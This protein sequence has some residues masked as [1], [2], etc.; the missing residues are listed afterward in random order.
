LDV[1]S[2]VLVEAFRSTFASL[3]SPKSSPR[4]RRQT[5]HIALHPIFPIPLPSIGSRDGLSRG[6]RL[7]NGR[8]GGGSGGRDLGSSTRLL[9]DGLSD[10]RRWRLLLGLDDWERKAKRQLL[11]STKTTSEEAYW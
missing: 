10:E 4:Y 7:L 8:S 1:R 5:T 2:V 3:V 11:R 9:G 6:R